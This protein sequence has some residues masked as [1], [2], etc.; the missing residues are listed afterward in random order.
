MKM[1]AEGGYVVGKLAQLLYP[2]IEVQEDNTELALQRT[3]ELLAQHTVTIHE[4]AL[5]SGQKLIRVDILKKRV[6]TLN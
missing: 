6:I 4:A 3:A 5:R 2:G 1:L